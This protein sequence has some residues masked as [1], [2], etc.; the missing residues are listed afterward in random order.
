MLPF[1]PRI[2]EVDSIHAFFTKLNMSWM[3][4]S[5]IVVVVFYLMIDKY[6]HRE[7]TKVDILEKAIPLIF[8]YFFIGITICTALAIYVD[9]NNEN[10]NK[11][12]IKTMFSSYR[13]TKIKQSKEFDSDITH[14]ASRNQKSEKSKIIFK[15]YLDKIKD[16]KTMELE[17][18]VVLDVLK[19]GENSFDIILTNG[20]IVTIKKKEA[21]QIFN[22]LK[23]ITANEREK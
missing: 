14:D 3:I 2:T 17:D 11:T 15:V 9:T 23:K 5:L 21:E 19:V 20:Q 6:I 13:I 1:L 8:L 10:I 18:D 7:A 22:T 4:V 16:V 12:P